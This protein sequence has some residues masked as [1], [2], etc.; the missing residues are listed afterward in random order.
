VDEG[1]DA[2]E[3]TEEH[4]RALLAPFFKKEVWLLP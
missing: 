3:D 1:K 4:A 2:A